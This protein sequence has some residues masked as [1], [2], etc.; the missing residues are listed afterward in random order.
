MRDLKISKIIV[1]KQEDS[2]S[3]YLNDIGQISL[4]NAEE[5]VRLARMIRAGDRQA[6]HKL[7]SANLRFVVSCAKK[8]AGKGISLQDLVNEGNLGLIRAAR[9]FDE[10][11]GFKFISYAVWWIRQAIMQALNENMRMIRVPMNQ[12]LAATA[13]LR[14][15]DRLTQLLERT[16]SLSEL[17]EAMNQSE[18]RL[19]ESIRNNEKTCSYDEFVQGIDAGARTMLELMESQDTDTTVLNIAAEARQHHVALLL[20]TLPVR[21]RTILAMSFGLEGYTAMSYEEIADRMG[22]SYERI[23]QIM[24]YTLGKLR[25]MPKPGYLREWA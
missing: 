4:I 10:T 7:V 24:A 9:N 14:E 20:K 16:P 25:K 12:Q 11:K 17:S 2:L 5:E 21:D 8:Y 3:R 22:Y 15:S 23:R 1:N 13:V 19:A 18:Q 6:E